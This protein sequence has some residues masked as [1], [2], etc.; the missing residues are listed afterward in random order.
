MS[1]LTPYQPAC[2]QAGLL[3]YKPINLI[4]KKRT[5]EK[6][7]KFEVALEK[8]DF[9]L[10]SEV[11]IPVGFRDYLKGFMMMYHRLGSPASPTLHWL[12]IYFATDED[13]KKTAAILEIEPD[14]LYKRLATLKR[15]YEKSHPARDTASQED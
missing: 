4:M 11:E 2:R 7:S 3:T 12:G 10:P 8:G 13:T 1:L 15:H 14:A 6:L 9:K 5:S